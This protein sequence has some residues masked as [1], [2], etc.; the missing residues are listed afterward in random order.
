MAY[1]IKVSNAARKDIERLPANIQ[2]RVLQ[3]ID[4]LRNDPRPSG[5]TKLR[6]SDAD[7]RIRVGDYRV[8]YEIDDAAQV[9]TILRARHR[10]D[11]YR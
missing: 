3:A 9:V 6:T 4:K 5:V 10:K 7:Y 8:K 2:R 11:A 1:R